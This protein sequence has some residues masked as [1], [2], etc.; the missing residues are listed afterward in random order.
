MHLPAAW[1]Q[2]AEQKIRT[3]VMVK[4]RRCISQFVIKIKYILEKSQ[5]MS[6][7]NT[8]ALKIKYDAIYCLHLLSIL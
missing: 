3:S 7:F 4:N 8:E 6:M 1:K 5:C 2:I